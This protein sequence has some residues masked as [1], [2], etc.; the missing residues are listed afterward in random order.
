ML[1]L[2]TFRCRSVTF[3]KSTHLFHPRHTAF[4]AE[5]TMG[6][7]HFAV[8]SGTPALLTGNKQSAPT[9]V[10][11]SVETLK[12]WL[13]EGRTAKQYDTPAKMLGAVK[14]ALK[15]MYACSSGFPCLQSRTFKRK[16]FEKVWNESEAVMFKSSR[17]MGVDA[18]RDLENSACVF[19]TD[20]VSWKAFPFCTSY[21]LSY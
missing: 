17:I 10:R 1:Y 19:R 16:V 18:S 12:K 9:T 2:S 13:R 3:D 8:L 7:K 20:F 6:A 15:G 14:R 21:N 4:H 5:G 11:F